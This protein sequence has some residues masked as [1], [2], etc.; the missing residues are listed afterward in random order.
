MAKEANLD[1]VEIAPQAK[2]PVCRIMNYGKYVF[3]Q[4]KKV[5]GQKTKQKQVQVKEV[6]FR[7]GTELGDYNVKMRNLVRFVNGGDRVKISLRFRGR[8]I[9][10]PEL[11]RKLLKR[12][13]ED[14]SEIAVVE[15]HPRMEG[16]QMVMMMAPKKAPTKSGK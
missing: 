16:R 1:L 2:P 13:E 10:H 8:E 14:L 3:E 7:P 5:Q 6:K 12:V 11:G 15:Q 4:K 9:T